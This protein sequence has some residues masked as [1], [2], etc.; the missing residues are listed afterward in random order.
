M[1]RRRIAESGIDSRG[2]AEY[3]SAVL[4]G[5]LIFGLGRPRERR[6]FFRRRI[7]VVERVELVLAT[8]T[9]YRLPEPTRVAD[10]LSRMHPT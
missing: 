5:C 10:K 8:V 6:P 2:A 7:G 1:S 3:A 4:S 9:R